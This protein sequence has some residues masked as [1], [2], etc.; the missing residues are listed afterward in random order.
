MN[1]EPLLFANVQI[2]NT[3]WVT[4]TNLNGNFE[5]SG[6]TPGKYILAIG[7]PG[8]ETLSIPIDVNENKVVEIKRELRANSIDVGALLNAD[9]DTEVKAALLSARQ[10]K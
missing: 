8:Y 4:Q 3:E 1:G 5:I 7:F 2:K 10:S 9:R 6:I